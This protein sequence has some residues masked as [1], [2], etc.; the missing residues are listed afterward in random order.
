LI[1]EEEQI[2]SARSA[3][4]TLLQEDDWNHGVAIVGVVL[5]TLGVIVGLAT[6]N[7]ALTGISMSMAVGGV[8]G[9]LAAGG[10]P[11]RAR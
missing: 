8:I 1:P 10:L 11:R 6:S 7:T 5:A 3:K 9:W 4:R 2:V